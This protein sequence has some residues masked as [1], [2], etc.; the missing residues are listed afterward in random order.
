MA[1]FPLFGGGLATFLATDV[2][3]WALF[4][5]SLNIL[6]GYTGLVSF[7]HA[8]YFGVGAYVAG[9]LLKSTEVS[10]LLALPLAAIAAGA[11][12]AIFGFFC[13]RLTKVYFSM[14]TL[15]FA[16]I[17]W[18]LCFKLNAFTGGDQGLSGIP[19][20]GFLQQL[21]G[22][23]VLRGLNTSERFH[24]LAV[25][26]A[27][28]C[29][30]LIHRI[31]SSPFGRVLTMI[32]EN[33]GRA[34]FVGVNVHRYQLAAFALAGLFAGIAGALFGIFNRGMY[35]DLMYWT[36]S[37]EVLIM[38]V[39]GGAG[40]FYGPI[41]GAFLL[42]WLNQELTAITEYWS[43]IVGLALLGLIFF[44]PGGFADLFERGFRFVVARFQQARTTEAAPQQ[45]GS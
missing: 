25:V 10:F 15:A 23:A 33:P 36:K 27:S 2:A 24:I 44:L 38:V 14:L 8:A 3:I 18:A 43:A 39:L 34:E 26:V 4:A 5:V 9:I 1:L 30:A 37:A 20:P 35:P 32:R 41:I 21:D 28:I 13:V 45:S 31:L 29:L 19:Y 7:G 40:R 17:A 12:A 11:L 42:L 6:V 16:Q 22:V